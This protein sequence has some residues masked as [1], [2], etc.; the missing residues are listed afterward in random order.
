MTKTK[1]EP[2]FSLEKKNG[3]EEKENTPKKKSSSSSSSS[4]K[5]TNNKTKKKATDTNTENEKK[6]QNKKYKLTRDMVSSD[7]DDDDENLSLDE[8]SEEET[9][10]SPASPTNNE[11]NGDD[12]EDYKPITRK[13]KRKQN[14]ENDGP[15]PKK[16]KMKCKKEEEPPH[17]NSDDE[18]DFYDIPD[19]WDPR[20]AFSTKHIDYKTWQMSNSNRDMYFFG[21]DNYI[22]P[23]PST[24]KKFIDA[25]QKKEID[26]EMV[27]TMVKPMKKI[28]GVNPS[29]HIGITGLRYLSGGGTFNVSPQ[30]YIAKQY[31]SEQNYTATGFKMIKIHMPLHCLDN[32]K[33]AFNELSTHLEK[34]GMK[35]RNKQ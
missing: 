19:G 33:N 28:V 5:K 31:Q 6:N 10:Y 2:S 14:D 13:R 21:P 18:R 32:V 34:L 7:S 11:S 27:S 35:K 16:M 26:E 1:E 4:S 8:S 3:E 25:I 20:R 23:N 24:M 9:K 22:Y 12:E 29:M 15:F 30:I 17:H